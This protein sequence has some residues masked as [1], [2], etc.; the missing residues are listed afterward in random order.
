M[1]SAPNLEQCEPLGG[2]RTLRRHGCPVVHLGP[3]HQNTHGR[4]GL[5][6]VGLAGG[7]RA[8]AVRGDHAPGARAH[9]AEADGGSWRIS[10]A[11]G[12][13]TPWLPDAAAGSIL[14][15]VYA[16][17][18]LPYVL[19]QTFTTTANAIFLQYTAP[20]Y[21]LFLSPWLLREKPKAADLL[22][23]AAC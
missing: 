14:A 6:V 3:V 11:P 15:I 7:G 20:V 22:T 13:A 21:I 18:L 1:S 8:L 23:F 2:S 12:R 5:G 17:T 19:A 4:I 16:G 9:L 10:V